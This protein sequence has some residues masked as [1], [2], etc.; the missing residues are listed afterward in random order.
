MERTAS[1]LG[2]GLILAAAVAWLFGSGVRAALQLLGESGR[3]AGDV[4]GLAAL[5]A[6]LLLAGYV[7]YEVVVTGE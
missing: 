2:L 1:T 5:A 6:F 7:L 3:Y 4:G